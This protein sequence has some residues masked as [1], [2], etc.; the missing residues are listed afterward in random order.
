MCDVCRS[1]G[2]AWRGRHFSRGGPA[3]EHATTILAVAQVDVPTHRRMGIAGL[4]C[5]ECA[6]MDVGA[7]LDQQGVTRPNEPLAGG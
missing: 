1:S 6:T 2:A 4:A 7:N 3:A 5:H